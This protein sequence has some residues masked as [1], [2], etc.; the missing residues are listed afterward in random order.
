MKIRWRKQMTGRERDSE[1]G[2]RAEERERERER[3][4]WFPDRVH[5]AG[6]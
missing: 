2:S 3:S 4:K 5:R 1:I 6:E